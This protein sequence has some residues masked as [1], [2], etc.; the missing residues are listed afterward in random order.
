M[1]FQGV[2]ALDRVSRPEVADMR[3]RQGLDVVQEAEQCNME[4]LSHLRSTPPLYRHAMFLQVPLNSA[5]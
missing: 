1:N 4:R 3:A 5:P 2:R